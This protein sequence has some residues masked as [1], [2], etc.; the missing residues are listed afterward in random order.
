MG[1]AIALWMQHRHQDRVEK[2][3]MLAPA[4]HPNVVHPFAQRMTWLAH[5]SPLV[6]GRNTI[7]ILLRNLYTDKSLANEEAIDEYFKPYLD[8]E[9]HEVFAKHLEALRDPK[10]YECLDQLQKPSL[11]LWGKRDRLVARKFINK[12]VEKLPLAQFHIHKTGGHHL[13][14]EDP[15]WCRD[16][17]LSFLQT[18]V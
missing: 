11:I 15:D 13:M 6:M 2:T 16:K 5:I 8:P 3:M 14:E 12:I 1:G 4:A 18:Q 17:I 7:R 9:A 10:V